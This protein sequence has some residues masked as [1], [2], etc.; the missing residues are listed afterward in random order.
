MTF[1]GGADAGVFYDAEHREWLQSLQ[2]GAWSLGFRAPAGIG[3]F[4]PLRATI[5][6]DLSAPGHTIV[7]RRGQC[8]GGNVADNPDGPI[9]AEWVDV[10]GTRTVSIDLDPAD[11]DASGCLWLRLNVDVTDFGSGGAI[12]QWKF[13]NLAVGLDVRVD[14]AEQQR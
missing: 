7:L 1:T 5:S 6:A 4:K 12:P 2:T 13:N 14:D 8:P 10:V 9:A 11:V 3:T